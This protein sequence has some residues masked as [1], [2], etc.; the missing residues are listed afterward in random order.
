MRRLSAA[1]ALVCLAACASP[2]AYRG[3]KGSLLAPFAPAGITDSASRPRRFALI[4]GVDEFED[5]RFPDL[6]YARADAETLAEALDDGFDHVETL[7]A[8]EQT[9]RT[10][11]IKAL[12]RIGERADRPT[13]TVL[14]YFST[15][16]SLAQEPGGELRRYL[17]ASDTA[18][19]LLSQTG[20]AVE[21]LLRAVEAMPS[22]RKLV[23]LATC[24]SGRGKSQLSDSLSEALAALKAPLQPIEQ[25]SEATIVLTASAFGD[26]ARESEELG[27]DIYTHFLLQALD[28]RQGDR[29]GNGAVTAS[30]AHDFA[31]DRTWAF[32]QGRQRPTAESRILGRD[33]IVLSGRIQRVGLPVLYSYAPSAEGLELRI[34]GQAKG[35]LPGGVALPEG[36]H[37]IELRRQDTDELLY[38]GEIQ[39]ERGQQADI[40]ELLPEP[41]SVVLLADGA[42]SWPF[43]HGDEYLPLAFGA[44]I[45]GW[46]RDW[47]AA[48]LR[49]GLRLA[50]LHGTGRAQGFGEQLAFDF[51]A[52]ELRA[53]AGYG[54][55]IAPGLELVPQGFVGVLWA[56]RDFDTPSYDELD[57]MCAL[58][59]GAGV[60]LDWDVAGGL[61]LALR[62]EIGAL[63]G[64]M[65]GQLDLHPQLGFRL[66]V[67]ARVW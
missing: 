51:H 16:G 14:V 2:G 55:A 43:D 38:A 56:F 60:S 11:I 26:T 12:A 52:L 40:S 15:H 31:R 3:D 42:G 7:S 25:V 37:R 61:Y 17:V 24:H 19:H 66:A 10:A 30:E 21:G 59:F 4:V 45:E 34:D 35:A 41:A 58:S 22:R 27:H 1:L 20:L 50:Y 54:L 8:R 9:T 33:P 6:R 32:T 57:R 47:P 53:Q 46:L 64:Q 39:L 23:I 67:G 65:G 18:M 48:Q 28:P 36:E 62:A 63:A 49:S 13:D 29:D 44:G 5:E